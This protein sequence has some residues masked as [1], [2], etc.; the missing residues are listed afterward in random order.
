MTWDSFWKTTNDILTWP[1]VQVVFIII[2]A[3][4]ARWVLLFV[5]R[6][7]VTQIVSGV[8]KTQNVDD[9]QALN[10]SPLSAV[11]TVQRTRTLGSVLTN[12]VNVLVVVVAILL[13]V[14][15]I[16]DTILSSFALLTAA[17]GAGLGFGAQN[18]V[19]DVLNGLFMVME[20]QLGVGD[21][22]DLGP[23]TG[24]V[25]AVGIRITQVR[26]VNGT[27]WFVRNGE[28][29][30]VGNMSQGWA[31]VII[32]LAVPYKT[33]V[34]AVQAEMLRVA[35]EMATNSKWRSRVLEKPE[36]WGLESISEEAIVIRIVIKT[37]TTAKDDVARE[38][39][40]R[41]KKALDAMGVQLPSLTSI[42]LTGFEGAA[43]VQGARPPRTTPLPVIEAPP[44]RAPR[45]SRAVK[46]AEAAAAAAAAALPVHP[47]APRAA[48]AK[49][50]TATPAEAS[51]A[52]PA[53]KPTAAQAAEAFAQGTT[54]IPS[55][56]RNQ[57]PRAP[58]TV[59]LP[60]VDPSAPASKPI[61]EQPLGAAA[62]PSAMPATK[63]VRKA[64]TKPVDKPTDKPAAKPADKPAE[65]PASPAADS[66]P[67][68]GDTDD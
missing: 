13:V 33:D 52:A 25:E 41:L 37:R 20:D 10:V 4:L 15:A 9:T 48:K 63:P 45:K 55:I 35:V 6:R 44:K 34:D 3:I 17:L 26:D 46:A 30:R 21:V 49:P 61:A 50:A 2:F 27:L 12:I 14:N 18:I 11:R 67:A 7:V 56:S 31:R 58:R 40:M 38:L 19:K 16:D 29:L 66:E 42:V 65:K 5:I 36:V 1:I 59:H 24:V 8:K 62:E 23:A 53:A 43:S 22:V 60:A 28:I 51:T 39:R 57:A 47:P 54:R 68:Q 64:V 32:D